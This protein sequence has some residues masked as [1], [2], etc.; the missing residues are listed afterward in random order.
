MGA[1][2]QAFGASDEASAMTGA[3]ILVDC[4]LGVQFAK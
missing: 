2:A 1:L 3:E 4:G